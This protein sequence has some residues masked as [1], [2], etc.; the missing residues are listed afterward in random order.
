M[1]LFFQVFFIILSAL[2]ATAFFFVG[3]W[4]SWNWAIICAIFA[5]VCY[6]L[7]MICK[8]SLARKNP[9]NDAQENTENDE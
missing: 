6:F 4:L 1:L 5:V 7:S 8:N 9:P 2:L 3:I